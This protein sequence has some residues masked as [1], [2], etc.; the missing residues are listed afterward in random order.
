M[1]DVEL[2]PNPTLRDLQDYVEHMVKERGFEGET[3]P[4]LFMLLLEECGEFAKAARKSSGIKTDDTSE[5]FK[6]SHEAV[7]IFW[8]LLEI[9]NRFNIDIEKAFREKEEI[10][11]KRSW[12]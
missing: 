11:K 7:D 1:A 9:C 8:Y 5:K 6:L 12:N 3:I 2:K 4:A 10:N